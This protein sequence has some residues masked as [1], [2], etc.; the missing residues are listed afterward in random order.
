MSEQEEKIRQPKQSR[1]IKTREAILQASMKLFSE[2]GYHLTNTKQIAALAG[3][4]TGSFYLYFKDK[5]A[6]FI[7]ALLLY[8]QE[9][10]R[11]QDE[12]IQRIDFKTEDKRAAIG[13]LITSLIESHDIFIEFHKELAVMYESDPEITRIMD[14]QHKNGRQIT[15]GYLSLWKEHLIV[16]DIEAASI[17]VF[18]ALNSLVDMIVF[19]KLDISSERIKAEMAEMI[20]NY[21]FG[22]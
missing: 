16:H 14:E 11:R 5:K 18:E 1:S 19:G 9:F 17:I 7:E 20:T 2:K 6:V 13:H 15:M 8:N 4:S 21:L 3:V 22:K 12:L 10:Q